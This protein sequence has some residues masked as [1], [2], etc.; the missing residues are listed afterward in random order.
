[1]CPTPANDALFSNRRGQIATL[2]ARYVMPGIFPAREF[3]DAGGLLSYGSSI[4][5]SFRQLGIYTG[6]ILKGE[7]TADLP[8]VQPTRFELVVNLSTARALGLAIPESFLLRADQ[9]IE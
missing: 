4:P 3:V 1:M 6:R 8:V 7:K 5:A 2:A 9:V